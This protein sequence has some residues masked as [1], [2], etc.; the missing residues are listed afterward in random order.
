MPPRLIRRAGLAVSKWRNGAGR[1]C[2][3]ATGPGWLVGFAF[4]D[5]DAPF[6]EYP[7]IDRTITLIEGPGFGLDFGTAAPALVVGM[8]FAPRPF[9]GGLAAQCRVAGGPC[10]VLNAIS[11]RAGWTH[12]VSVGALP[13]GPTDPGIVVVLRGEVANVDAANGHAV[14]GFRDSW[15]LA[16]PAVLRASPDALVALIRIVPR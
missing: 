1:K 7:G 16:G 11:E 9:D 6:S 10:V 15:Q 4:L 3:I 8:P 13:D 12:T 2:D 14:A 5:Q